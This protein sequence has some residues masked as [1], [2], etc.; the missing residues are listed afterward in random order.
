MTERIFN[1]LHT[2]HF[3]ASFVHWRLIEENGTSS[4]RLEYLNIFPSFFKKL[5][6][7]APKNTLTV[8]VFYLF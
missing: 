1:A 7:R 3:D 2:Q 6:P 5:T 4:K 8:F